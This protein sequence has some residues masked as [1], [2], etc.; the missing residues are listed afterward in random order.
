MI[1]S[2]DSPRGSHAL[3]APCTSAPF[4]M[5]VSKPPDLAVLTGGYFGRGMA[6]PSACDSHQKKRGSAHLGMWRFFP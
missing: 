2:L 3:V 1:T 5:D 4:A 6:K